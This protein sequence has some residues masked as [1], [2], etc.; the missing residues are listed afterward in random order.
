MIDER[1]LNMKKEELVK[2][3]LDDATAEKVANASAEE[4]K[5]FVPKARFDEVNTAKKTAEDLVKARDTQIE[6]LKAAGSVDDLKQQIATLQADNKKKDE[7]HAAQ[8]HQMQVDNAVN[9]ALVAAKAKNAK[10]VAALLDLKNAELAEDG[11]VKGLSDQLKKLAEA[12]D[13]KF[14]FDADKKPTLKGA[15]V[16]EHGNESDDHAVDTSKMSY[17]E[18]CAYLSENPEANLE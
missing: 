1:V 14:L 12:N 13:S 17:D 8:I 3:G 2:L 4:L 7:E 6:G 16:G 11:T 18:L 5:G 9:A 10:A 15:K